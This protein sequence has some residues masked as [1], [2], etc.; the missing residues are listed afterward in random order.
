MAPKHPF[1]GTIAAPID[2]VFHALTD[3]TRIP[4]W[5]PSCA[6]VRTP[7]GSLSKGTQFRILFSSGRSRREAIAEVIEFSPPTIFGWTETTGRRN[8]KTFYR[9]QFN[10]SSTGVVMQHVIASGGLLGRLRG[11]LFTR[12]ETARQFSQSLQNLQKILAR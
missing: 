6:E 11:A 2:D 3:P 9:L 5:L 1:S 7:S 10:G 8:T 4:Q 12:R